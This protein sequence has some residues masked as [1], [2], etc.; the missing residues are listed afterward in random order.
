MTDLG[1]KKSFL[2][3]GAIRTYSFLLFFHLLPVPWFF[4]V[5]AGL[6]PPVVFLA[7]GLKSLFVTES[8]A[9]GFGSLLVLLAVGGGLVC[10]LLAWL[11]TAA[12]V[13][14]RPLMIR[15]A[16]L[17]ALL[18]VAFL[19]AV[20]PIYVYGGHSG[21]AALSL[22]D[23]IDLLADLRLPAGYAV[24]YFGLLAVLL[25]SFLVYQHWATHRTARRLKDTWRRTRRPRRYTL[26]AGSLGLFCP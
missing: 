2:P 9:L 23:Y 16:S 26:A 19:A 25:L 21:S 15:T 17:I 11:L 12:L 7:V 10:Y 24:A 5:V 4:W 14:I 22:F 18:A 8:G 3:K 20:N 6:A 13:R 1:Y